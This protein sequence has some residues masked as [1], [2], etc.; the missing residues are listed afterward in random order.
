MA[1]P[2]GLGVDSGRETGLPLQACLLISLTAPADPGAL[3]GRGPA[4]DGGTCALAP[5]G[6]RARGGRWDPSC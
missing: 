1:P 6:G 5:V 2:T 3:G 4:A